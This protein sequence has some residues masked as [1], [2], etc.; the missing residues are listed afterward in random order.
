MHS[1]LRSSVVLVCCL[2]AVQALGLS[3]QLN[4]SSAV[5]GHIFDGIGGLSAGASSRLLYDYPEPQRSEI[6]DYLFL[7]SF[8]ASLQILKVEVGGDHQSTDGT[9]P[10]HWHARAQEVS[11]RRGYELWLMQEAVARNPGI[12]T[13]GMSWNAPGWVGNGSFYSP[14]GVEYQVAWM[15]CVHAVLGEGHPSFMGLWNEQAQPAPDY[16]LQLRASMDAAGLGHTKLMVMDGRYNGSEVAWAQSNDTYREAVAGAGLHYP[17]SVQEPAVQELG[18]LWWA[19]EDNSRAPTWSNGGTYWGKALSQNYVLNNMTATISWALLWA[20]YGNVVA[21][22]PLGG[23]T[24]SAAGLMTAEQPWSGHYEVPSPIWLSAHTTQFTR[25]GWVYLPVGPSGGS[26][27]LPGPRGAAVSG[28]YVTLVSL[29]PSDP[30][31][32]LVLESLNNSDCSARALLPAQGSNVSVQISGAAQLPW[33]QPGAILQVWRS[34]QYA[35]FVQQ[36][37][38]TLDPSSSFT[39][40]LPSDGMVTVST[41]NTARHGSFPDSPVPPA[42]PFTLPYSDSFEGYPY[43][44]LPR[45]FADQA[46]S[47]AVREGVMVQVAEGDAGANGCLPEYGPL[48]LFGDPAWVNYT[49]SVD[50]L[51]NTSSSTRPPS[52]AMLPSLPYARVCAR[53]TF[54]P[55]FNFNALSMPGYCLI[56]QQGGQWNVTANGTSVAGGVYSDAHAAGAT[57]RYTL[58]LTVQGS[59]ITTALNNNSSDPLATVSDSAFTVGNAAL[60]TSYSGVLLDD[61]AVLPA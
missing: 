40:W 19:S 6:L 12:R 16:V 27:F 8:G 3:L 18:W 36:Q 49:V 61:F 50:A 45:Y 54:F 43:D 37:S 48:S 15:H 33:L 24:I 60:G 38:V 23:S 31:F 57:A 46:G 39:V 17:C 44:A 22:L 4:I 10:S 53:I 14:E 26:G 55:G 32:T 56:L 58:S 35:L 42:A 13:Y 5:A 59:S 21:Q 2:A 11:C 28:T 30:G 34:T 41:V 47:Y 7:P 29:D 20:S 1:H 9:E 51:F 25:P 52:T